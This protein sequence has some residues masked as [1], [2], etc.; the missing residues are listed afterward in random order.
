MK[1][2]HKLRLNFFYIKS[3]LPD[4]KYL[5]SH[6]YDPS[7][8]LEVSPQSAWVVEKLRIRKDFFHLAAEFAVTFEIEQDD[9]IEVFNSVLSKLKE[10][11]VLL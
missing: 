5:L 8:T 11:Q 2:F 4:G 1:E 10:L 6:R 9:C 3:R 7:K